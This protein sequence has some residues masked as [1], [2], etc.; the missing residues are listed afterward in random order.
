MKNYFFT[1]LLII[2][3]VPFLTSCESD[4]KED[5]QLYELK[6]DTI[7]A[8]DKDEIEEPGDRDESLDQN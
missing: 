7:Q 2:F 6:D 1:I 5:E 8:I 4:L 3:A